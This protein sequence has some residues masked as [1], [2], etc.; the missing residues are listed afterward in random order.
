MS[1]YKKHF[2]MPDKLFNEWKKYALKAKKDGYYSVIDILQRDARYNMIFGERSNGKTYSVLELCVIANIIMGWQGAL[3]R[4]METDFVGK[5][6]REMFQNINNNG[7]VKEL[8]NG[9]YDYI[10]YRASAWYLAKYD[11]KLARDILAAEPLMYAFALST[12]EHDKSTGYPN[13][14]IILF[15]E[16][17]TRTGYL[18]DEFT[19]F[20]NTISTIIRKR[21]D[22]MIFMCANTVNRYCIY[23]DEMGIVNAKSMKA[24]DI[25]TIEYGDSGL[26]TAVEYAEPNVKGKP[27]DIY[28]AFNNP[29]LKMITQGSWELDIYPHCP[30]STIKEKN[31][32]FRYFIEFDKELFQC[33]LVKNGTNLFTYIH[34]KTTPL[35]K[36][37]KDIIFSTNYDGRWNWSRN[38]LKPKT[39]LEQLILKFFKA[40]KVFYSSNDVGDT[41]KNYIDW[42]RKQ[43]V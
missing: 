15:D 40:D 36:T 32:V 21:D 6:G 19:L 43:S 2:L 12:Q 14:K 5:R 30:L 34:R 7:L 28:F 16:F 8:T 41:I 29:K 33:N 18:T 26:R 37:D 25:D 42:C 4:R 17:I 35:K 23:F 10:K 11:E 38:I 1:R 13:V 27:S 39:K 9:K 22:V 31:I 20:G 24:G 3:I